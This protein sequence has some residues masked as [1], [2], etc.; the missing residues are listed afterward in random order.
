MGGEDR[1]FNKGSTFGKKGGEDNKQYSDN[2]NAFDESKTNTAK[3]IDP[4]QEG[5][6][7]QIFDY[8]PDDAD[9]D[10]DAAENNQKAQNIQICRIDNQSGEKFADHR[11]VG[12]RC[13]KT[14]QNAN[15][16]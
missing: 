7:Q 14:A 15:N 4:S 3:A 16:G 9:D 1:F 2:E 6:I 12:I 8:N 10:E 11:I 13:I 5:H